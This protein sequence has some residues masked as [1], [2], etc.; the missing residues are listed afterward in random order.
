MENTQGDSVLM[1]NVKDLIVEVRN[2]SLQRVGQILPEDLQDFSFGIRNNG[3]GDWKIVLPANHP[4]VDTL[5][6]PGSGIIVSSTTAVLFSGPTTF[7]KNVADFVNPKGYWEIEGATDN[8]ILTEK[9]AFPTPTTADVSAQSISYDT[10]VGKAQKI[11]KDY[12]DANIGPSAPVE[13]RV[14]NLTIEAGDTL[15]PTLTYSARFDNL[16]KLVYAI[17]TVGKLSYNIVQEGSNLV[18]KV[19]APTD[20]SAAIRMD[21][22]N[23]QLEKTEYTYRMPEVTRVIVGGAGALT[24]RE[25][26][27]RTSTDSLNAETAWGRKIEVFKDQRSAQS[28]DELENAGDEELEERGKTIETVVVVPN[29]NQ[30]MVFGKDWFLGDTV[31][32]I[33]GNEQITQIVKEVAVVVNDSGLSLRATVGEITKEDFEEQLIF[34]QGRADDRLDN[35][36]RNNEAGA[37]SSRQTISYTSPTLAPNET[38]KTTISLSGGYR[39]LN[40]DTTIPCRVR[41]YTDTTGQDNDEFRALGA[42][43]PEEY[44]CMFDARTTSTKLSFDL[45]PVVDGF[46]TDGSA[47]VPLTIT[48]RGTVSTPIQVSFIYVSTE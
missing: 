42:Y 27:Q 21:I 31:S 33:V 20:R 22:F 45:N 47:T 2:S 37:T 41:L 32:V 36:E 8:I 5:R 25:F 16:D 24:Q 1:K 3:V 11:M 43:P 23:G 6:T 4:L 30:N 44:G 14:S 29:E 12:V 17:A 40:F 18:F 13:R 46:T 26:L 35:L 15:G 39:L 7:A 9:L 48:N 28:E 38:F 34:L 10:R 19:Y